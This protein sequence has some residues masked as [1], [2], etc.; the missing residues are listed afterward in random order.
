MKETFHTFEENQWIFE[1]YE[2][3]ILEFD[4]PKE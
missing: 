4:I 3:D 2:Q 1:I